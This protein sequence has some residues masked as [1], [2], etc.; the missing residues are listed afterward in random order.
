MLNNF[1]ET[2]AME[3]NL[4]YAKWRMLHGVARLKHVATT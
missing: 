1:G 4:K 3:P 2:Y